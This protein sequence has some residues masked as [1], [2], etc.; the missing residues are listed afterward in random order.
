VGECKKL[1]KMEVV[2]SINSRIILLLLCA[3]TFWR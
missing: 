1:V 2:N 3:T